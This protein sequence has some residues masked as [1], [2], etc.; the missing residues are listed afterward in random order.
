MASKCRSSACSTQSPCSSTSGCQAARAA[1]E[2]SSP[3]PGSGGQPSTTS[4]TACQLLLGA[5]VADAAGAAGSPAGKALLSP[6]A[7]LAP[8]LPT[9]RSPITWTRK[10][11]MLPG[12]YASGTS[13]RCASQQLP[14]RAPAARHRASACSSTRRSTAA[15]LAALPPRSNTASTVPLTCW[16]AWV[17]TLSRP[18][19]FERGCRTPICA[20][21]SLPI[22]HLCHGGAH[23][24]GHCGVRRADHARRAPQALAAQRGSAA[25]HN[26]W[27]VSCSPRHGGVW[28]QAG[29]AGQ[30]GIEGPPRLLAAQQA[31]A[32]PPW[33]SLA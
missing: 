9:S 8:R 7:A 30:D 12:R 33:R 17:G 19:H 13:S 20:H 15:R 31:Q 25:H 5:S 4:G 22:P 23:G 14:G 29:A 21:A 3:C 28:L 10:R 26:H 6:L 1:S 11:A 18:G 2:G 16:A 27:N 32:R 24:A